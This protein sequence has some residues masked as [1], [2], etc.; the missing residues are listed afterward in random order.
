MLVKLVYFISLAFTFSAQA[1]LNPHR[2]TLPVP[3]KVLESS[4]YSTLVQ[5]GDQRMSQIFQTLPPSSC[6]VSVVTNNGYFYVTLSDSKKVVS[7]VIPKQLT[8]KQFSAH[9]AQF[10]FISA[11]APTTPSLGAVRYAVGLMHKGSYAR[12]YIYQHT[13]ASYDK[14]TIVNPSLTNLWM[15]PHV[16]QPFRDDDTRDPILNCYFSSQR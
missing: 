12:L 15:E 8:V 13:F 10:Y 14:G 6:L 11:D 5:M 16:Q 7:I 3:N 1:Q 2:Y 9:D 4:T